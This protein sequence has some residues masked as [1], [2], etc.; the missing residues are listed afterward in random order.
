[1]SQEFPS[2][3]THATRC[4]ESLRRF[5]ERAAQH[6]CLMVMPVYPGDESYLPDRG[7]LLPFTP[8]HRQRIMYAHREPEYHEFIGLCEKIWVCQEVRKLEM[9]RIYPGRHGGE[10]HPLN[11]AP[12]GPLCNKARISHRR[13]G[14]IDYRFFYPEFMRAME[15]YHDAQHSQLE[16][17]FE[18]AKGT[19]TEPHWAPYQRGRSSGKH[20]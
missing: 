9:D 6:R 18:S 15:A 8:A 12:L 7:I 14:W 4:P 13:W 17:F 3:L 2:H 20:F 11:I 1:M 16:F 19:P 5:V 10:Y